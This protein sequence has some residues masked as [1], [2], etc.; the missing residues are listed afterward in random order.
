MEGTLAQYGVGET[1]WQF[2][3]SRIELGIGC[4][5]IADSQQQRAV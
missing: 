3:S 5:T 4:T 2:R 1:V